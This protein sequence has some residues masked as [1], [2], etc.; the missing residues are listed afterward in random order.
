VT[1]IAAAAAIMFPLSLFPASPSP[2]PP[3]APPPCS[4]KS[5][6]T[7][8][9]LAKT[10]LIEP[11]STKVK[12]TPEAETNTNPDMATHWSQDD[13]LDRNYQMLP[14]PLDNAPSIPTVEENFVL[15]PIP[16]KTSNTK[17]RT[18][19]DN[20]DNDDE[21]QVREVEIN[22]PKPPH[23]ITLYAN[24]RSYTLHLAQ[25][26]NFWVNDPT[27]LSIVINKHMVV[28]EGIWKQWVMDDLRYFWDK[29]GKHQDLSAWQLLREKSVFFRVL[30]ERFE[31]IGEEG[32]N[33][34]IVSLS[35]FQA[36][37]RRL[38]VTFDLK[39]PRQG[40]KIMKDMATEEHSLQTNHHYH[41]FTAAEKI[42]VMRISRKLFRQAEEDG[43]CGE[44]RLLLLEE[45]GEVRRELFE[46]FGEL[47]PVGRY[48]DKVASWQV[49]GEKRKKEE[50]EIERKRKGGW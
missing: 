34:G 10:Y 8:L 25:R 11:S 40:L 49:A 39:L 19:N 22:P 14:L 12:G 43:G 30:R 7:Q 1:Q 21:D 33:K 32:K 13:T 41:A 15:V 17:N 42:E 26:M 36:E 9:S 44:L 31:G 28:P 18:S 23:P 46:R 16:F 38:L 37:I 6:V 20:D 47:D 35:R 27:R 45:M 5:S 24:N 4:T 2:Q 29:I 48:F 3:T 50:E